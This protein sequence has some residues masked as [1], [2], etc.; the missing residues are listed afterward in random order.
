MFLVVVTTVSTAPLAGFLSSDHAALQR[1]APRQGGGG[2]LGDR[3]GPPL[4]AR[5][6]PGS[7]RTGRA[8]SCPASSSR[9]LAPAPT[10]RS[11]TLESPRSSAEGHAARRLR[12]RDGAGP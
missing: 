2:L 9:T 11:Y 7:L 12:E 3:S 4:P 5:G 1:D 6:S 8:P 10:D